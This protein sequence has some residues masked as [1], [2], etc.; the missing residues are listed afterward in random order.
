MLVPET[1]ETDGLTLMRY[2]HGVIGCVVR[3]SMPPASLRKV[4]YRG[5]LNS[6]PQRFL[7]THPA[8]SM[9]RE[10][11]RDLIANTPFAA[12]AD[13]D[14]AREFGSFKSPA[15]TALTRTAHYVLML[16]TAGRK[17]MRRA[18]I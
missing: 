13:D 16:R 6:Q 1:R 4:I 17:T 10:N 12:C 2:R 15:V 9:G 7:P 5:G 18:G 8:F 11:G 14:D 3:S